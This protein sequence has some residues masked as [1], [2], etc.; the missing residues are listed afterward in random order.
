M[1]ARPT[2]VRQALERSPEPA[3]SRSGVLPRTCT[4]ASCADTGAHWA[5]S[6]IAPW[7]D[8]ERPSSVRAVRPTRRKD[9]SSVSVGRRTFCSWR[10]WDGRATGRLARVVD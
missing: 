6:R 4:M 7:V 9:A 3:P 1:T 2:C 8:G 5:S 10:D